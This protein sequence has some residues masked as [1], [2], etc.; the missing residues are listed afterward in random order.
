M[1]RRDVWIWYVLMSSDVC[2]VL[3]TVSSSL[4]WLWVITTT[5]YRFIDDLWCCHHIVVNNRRACHMLSTE[6]PQYR[7]CHVRIEINI[8]CMWVNTRQCVSSS[9]LCHHNNPAERLL[10]PTPPHN[11][12]RHLISA[13]AVAEPSVATPG[14]LIF[15]IFRH[16]D[17][18]FS[19]LWCKTANFSRQGSTRKL[20][21][22]KISQCFPF[23]SA[24]TIYILRGNC[25]KHLTHEIS[26]TEVCKKKYPRKVSSDP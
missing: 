9:A 4:C 23:A 19:S 7:V 2:G 15:A 11:I 5:D 8:R 17:A 10:W 12:C 24:S 26:Q 18:F 13:G 16:S 1:L 20:R 22:Y 6:Q 25:F 14:S 21:L 3:Q